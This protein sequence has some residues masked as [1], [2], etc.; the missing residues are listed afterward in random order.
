MTIALGIMAS[1]GVVL[2]ADTQESVPGYW[3]ID[4]GKIL[5][6]TTWNLGPPSYKAAWLFSGAGNAG[7]VDALIQRLQGL[8]GERPADAD[9]AELRIQALVQ[10]FH[11]EHVAPFTADVPQVYML[12]GAQCNHST[13]L[14]TTEKSTIARYHHYAAVGIGN[15]YAKSILNRLWAYRALDVAGTV[16]LAAYVV[17][18]TKAFIEGCGN[19]TDIY[20][21]TNN[22]VGKIPRTRI[23][24]MEQ[25]FRGYSTEL[26]PTALRY[27]FGA[28][29]ELR[30]TTTALRRM[31][32]QLQQV[33]PVPA[34]QPP[35]AK[36]ED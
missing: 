9:E 21:L 13:G 15:H 16:A 20:F 11:A 34:A 22:D 19:F 36:I 12:V 25:V 26:E 33:V 17:F 27:A 18:Q 28:D 35:E 3:K 8:V 23:D 30:S 6:G 1:D 14:W 10:T 4:Q 24:R 2:A 32:K 31:R 5:G 7:Y 29:G